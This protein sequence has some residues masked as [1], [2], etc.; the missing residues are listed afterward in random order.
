[1]SNV[2][3]AEE[4]SKHNFESDLWIVYKNGVYDITKFFKE[5]PGGEEVL[6]NLAGKDATVCFDDI[7][8]TTEAVQLR[9]TYKIGTMT[10]TFDEKPSYA[11]T[12]ADVEKETSAEDENWK[13]TE[14]TN[15]ENEPGHATTIVAAGVVI[16]AIIIYYFFLS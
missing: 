8:H 7:G 12:D 5:H 3:T 4:V 15:S 9:E 11:S 1:M 13:Y 16:Y 2:Y 14:S 6:L 10:G